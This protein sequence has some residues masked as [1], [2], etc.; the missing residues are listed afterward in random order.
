MSYF[1][2]LGLNQC[3]LLSCSHGQDC[4]VDKQ[5]IAN[6]VCSQT[7]EPIV[8]PVCANNGNTFDN[9]CEMELNGCQDRLPLVAKYFGTC[10]T[11]ILYMY[12][13]TPLIDFNVC[14][15]RKCREKYFKNFE[16]KNEKTLAVHIWEILIPKI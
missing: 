2:F 14:A 1:L 10:G 15:Q 13:M 8:R 4:E 7:C 6:C 12:N 11:C 16:M 9:L 5:G 3:K